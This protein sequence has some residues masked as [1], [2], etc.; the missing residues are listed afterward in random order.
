MIFS[1][2]TNQ[3]FP[4]KSGNL[5][6]TLSIVPSGGGEVGYFIA[7]KDSIIFLRTKNL[8]IKDDKIV[9]GSTLEEN[10]LKLSNIQLDKAIKFKTDLLKKELKTNEFHENFD[11]VWLFSLQLDDD[12]TLRTNSYLL[13]LNHASSELKSFINFLLVIIPNKLKLEGFS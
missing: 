12:L 7:I 1:S 4:Q 8:K 5:D 11:D 3:T 10:S 6:I 9:L 2:C 13:S